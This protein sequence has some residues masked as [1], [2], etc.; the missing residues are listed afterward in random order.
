MLVDGAYERMV[1]QRG[2]IHL[3]I[4]ALRESWQAKDPSGPRPPLASGPDSSC[5]G[6]TRGL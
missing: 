6:S 4:G 3:I 1:K 5:F 2:L